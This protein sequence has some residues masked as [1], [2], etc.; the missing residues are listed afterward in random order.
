MGHEGVPWLVQ[1]LG[2]G[3]FTVRAQVQSLVGELRSHKPHGQIK[4]KEKD[5]E[6]Q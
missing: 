5:Q 2:L 6:M 4:K 1:W 3:A